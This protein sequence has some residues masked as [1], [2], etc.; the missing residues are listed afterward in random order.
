MVEQPKALRGVEGK[1]TGFPISGG[2]LAF[3]RGPGFHPTRIRQAFP[4]QGREGACGLCRRG[5]PAR[6]RRRAARQNRACSSWHLTSMWS[7]A[8]PAC[9]PACLPCLGVRLPVRMAA[10][11]DSGQSASLPLWWSANFS[12]SLHLHLH[13]HLHLRLR[14][15]LRLPSISVSVSVSVSISLWYS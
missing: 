1:C 10:F 8:L 12:F 15:R 13:L 7:A 14:L 5:W 9:L 6:R 11:P 3:R 4:K 2:Y